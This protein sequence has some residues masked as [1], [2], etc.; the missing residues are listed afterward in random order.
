MHTDICARGFALTPA[1]RR[2]VEAEAMELGRHAPRGIDAVSVRLF[3][4]NGPRGGPDKGCLV[5]LRLP[6]SRAA[7]VASAIDS[8]LYRAISGA[9]MKLE[10]ATRATLQRA[11][12]LRRRVPAPGQVEQS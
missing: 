8:D 11:R 12:A 1:L 5:A 10:R 3:D 2:A 4:T 7:V 9:F 6:G